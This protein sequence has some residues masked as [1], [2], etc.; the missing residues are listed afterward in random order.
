LQPQ[1]IVEVP[2]A[3]GINMCKTKGRVFAPADKASETILED[4]YEKPETAKVKRKVTG[5]ETQAEADIA[6][7]KKKE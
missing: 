7:G 6:E 2:D 5:T 1:D 4:T 3:V